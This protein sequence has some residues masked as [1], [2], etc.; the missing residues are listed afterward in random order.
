[1]FGNS[2]PA[3]L[4]RF[5]PGKGPDYRENGAISQGPFGGGARL[6]PCRDLNRRGF[7]GSALQAFFKEAG[8]REESGDFR[9]SRISSGVK[10]PPVRDPEAGT[11]I[12]FLGVE[13]SA[14]PA[15]STK[16]SA[17]GGRPF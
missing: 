4:F 9:R 16:A 11:R 2:F 3:A 5:P 1:L 13:E 8:S 14:V 7:I 17:G 15:D 10:K 6:F 12:A